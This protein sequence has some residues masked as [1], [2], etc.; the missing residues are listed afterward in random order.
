MIATEELD[1][2]G[3]TVYVGTG[4]DCLE[5]DTEQAEYSSLPTVHANR[6]VDRATME[7]NGWF[8]NET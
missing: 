8:A 2:M 5:I 3:K 7:L 4:D 1:E 6:L